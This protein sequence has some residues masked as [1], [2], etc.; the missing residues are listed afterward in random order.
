MKIEPIS[1]I[2]NGIGAALPRLEDPRLLTGHG[3]FADDV[4][5]PGQARGYVLRSPVAHARIRGID[6]S[7][8]LE[9]PGLIAVLTGEDYAADGL[10]NIPCVSIPPTISGKTYHATPFPPLAQER[11]LAVGTGVAFVIADTLA[12]AM[13]AAERI[14][15]DYE[16]LPA[17]PTVEA[18]L[19]PAA[20]LV[21]PQAEGNRCFVHE[22]GKADE[23]TAAFARAD[24]VVRARIRTQRLAGNPLEP[25]TCLGAYLEGD[26]RWFLTTSTSNPHRIRLLL[27]EHVF[28]VPAHRLHVVAGDVG[29]GFGT[30]GGLYPEEILVLWAA[31]R[32][33]RPVKWVCDRSEAFLSDFNGRDQIAD[34]ELA[35]T[36]EGDVLGVRIVLNHNL[37]CQLGPST[38]HPPL[39]GAR[40]L[41]G[42]YAF[43][44]MHV[45][46]NGI[47]THSRTL[48]TYRGAGR[49]EATL[50]IE[51]MLDIAADE[52][53]LDR[54]EIRRRNLIRPEQMPYRT[55]IG[56]TYD[57]GEFGPLMEQAL[58]LAD[59]YGFEARRTQSE[60]R[61]KL[62]GRGLS[63]YI[64]VC[65]TISDRMEVRF[66][67]TGGLSILAGTFSYGQGHHTA[68]AQMAHEWLGVPLDRIRFVQGDT[69][70]IATGRGSFGSR[71]MTVGGSA[72][73]GACEQVIERGGL[74]AAIL[75]G[76]DADS[77]RFERGVYRFEAGDTEVTLER[78]ARA[79]LAWGAPKPLPPEL[80]SGLEGRGYYTANPQNY[81]NGCYITEVEVD[82]ESGEVTLEQVTAVDDVGTVIN[83]LIL[84]GQIHGGIAQAAG[85]ALKEAIVHD[86][87]GQLLTGSFTDY[88]MPQAGDFPR[89][90]LAMRPVP[91]K[92][93][94][95]GVKGGAE[96]GTVGLP[97]AIIS[98]IVDALKPYGVRDIPAPL[99]PLAVWS[100]IAAAGRIQ[101][102]QQETRVSTLF[103]IY[104]LDR[105]DGK[106][107]D[108]RAATR[109]LHQA[110]MKQFASRARLGGP[111]L[112]PDGA[113]CGGLM[114][115][116]AESEEEVRAMLREDPFE[117]AQLSERIDVYPFRWQTNRPADLPP[118]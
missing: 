15:V 11:V 28:R 101:P 72:L 54:V 98:A 60:K 31:Q 58:E 112:G 13:D 111:V 104:R 77:L 75:L 82:P 9:V 32:V 95:L 117:Q 7:G 107:A 59:W 113:P 45:T 44:A 99:T 10:G 105:R 50:V 85:Q 94:P 66:D 103:M 22:L 73:K 3:R 118:L 81:P 34:A 8:A 39:V 35:L 71:S 83:P 27:A 109:P 12:A 2:A 21:W 14:V 41:S 36:R 52:L 91:T 116:E 49:P 78:V 46:I 38:A 42:V 47:F 102:N 33:G 20:P 96:T 87:D 37:G 65:A 6:V 70:T 57:C 63:M 29:G 17:A 88:A 40:M 62:R 80:W 56:E 24:H 79:T 89:F 53:G 1:R 43:P 106:A 86:A 25:R 93:N 55:A 5:L 23:T 114:L 97:P 108:I 92:T 69:D 19:A 30:K 67:A 74:V 100:A 68:Y 51:R 16:Q 48:T 4:N 84:Q 18:A 64:E 115:I 76:C 90:R 61:G 110:Y 26:Q